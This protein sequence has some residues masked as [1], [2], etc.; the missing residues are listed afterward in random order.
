MR[1][2]PSRAR[3]FLPVAMLLALFALTSLFVTR[4]SLLYGVESRV[5]AQ[6]TDAVAGYRNEID[7]AAVPRDTE[8]RRAVE[9]VG[10]TL[11]ADTELALYADGARAASTPGFAQHI[12]EADAGDDDLAA[13]ESAWTTVTASQRGAMSAGGE[14]IDYL[15]V[16]ILAG[17]EVDGVLVAIVDS[18][19]WRSTVGRTLSTVAAALGV[20]LLIGL[21]VA[22]WLTGR[23]MRLGER[24][25][26]A[27]PGVPAE[28]GDPAAPRAPAPRGDDRVPAATGAGAPLRGGPAATTA[29]RTNAPGSTAPGST[30]SGAAPAHRPRGRRSTAR[31]PQPIHR[32]PVELN[33]VTLDVYT[34][35]QRLADRNWVLDVPSDERVRIDPEVVAVAATRLAEQ[36]AR[37]TSPG[38]TIVLGAD[39]SN[40]TA[41]VH[42]T[43]TVS[44]DRFARADAQTRFDVLMG[45]ST[46][47]GR[48][49][50]GDIRAA[51][52]AHGGR[53]DVTPV[54]ETG[55]RVDLVLPAS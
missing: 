24:G 53:L 20:M 30:P 23:L 17:D 54:G 39:A 9:A 37:T 6:L 1:S 15:A 44:D 2:R 26:L 14:R 34:H 38:D 19:A 12:G 4:Q 31:A 10:P 51:A 29:S 41:R 3:L 47:E 55:V 32:V 33:R 48:R 42:V 52:E 45:T 27:D 7:E 35:A 25:R 22:W 18:S 8:L 46:D 16:P 50:V 49:A 28:T 40:G 36:A 13:Q 11:D 21:L 5:G 43:T